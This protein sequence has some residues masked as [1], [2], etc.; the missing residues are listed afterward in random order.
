MHTFGAGAEQV[1]EPVVEGSSFSLFSIVHS[2]RNSISSTDGG[3]QS[4]SRR[5]GL[6]KVSQT[7]VR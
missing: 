6:L 3:I 2:E 1:N 5:E 7:T 4:W